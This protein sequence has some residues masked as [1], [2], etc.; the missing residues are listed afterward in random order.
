MPKTSV[1]TYVFRNRHTGEIVKLLREDMTP[2]QLH[3]CCRDGYDLIAIQQPPQ[4]DGCLKIWYN[5]YIRKEW[6]ESISN[7][8]QTQRVKLLACHALNWL[9]G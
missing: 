5:M 2:G 8:K 9:G 1:K 4:F 6:S 3:E 7:K